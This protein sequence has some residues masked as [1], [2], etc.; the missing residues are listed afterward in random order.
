MKLSYFITRGIISLGLLSLA[1]VSTQAE[2]KNKPLVAHA[3]TASPA[4]AAPAVAVPLAPPLST[5]AVPRKATDGRDPFFPNSSR[6]YGT[7]AAPTNRAPAI[8]ADLILKGISG[9]TEQPLAI[10]NTT[11]FTAGESNEVLLKN[12]RIRIQ[13]VEINMTAGTV[14]LQV[15]SE[16]RELRLGQK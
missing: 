12:G 16:R 1:L 7:E 5:F 13:C 8:V 14:L 11:T 6:V 10:I 15:G 2:E 9:T 3:R 4:V